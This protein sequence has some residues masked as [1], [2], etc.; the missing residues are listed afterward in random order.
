MT[1]ARWVRLTFTIPLKVSQQRKVKGNDV[2]IYLSWLLLLFLN[3]FWL[4]N[5]HRQVVTIN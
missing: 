1:F 2:G 4:S 3:V 5:V